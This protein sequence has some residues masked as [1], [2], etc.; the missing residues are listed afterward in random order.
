MYSQGVPQSQGHPDAVH[1]GLDALG[2]FVVD[3]LGEISGKGCSDTCSTFCGEAARLD[4]VLGV[5]HR[6]L[7][8]IAR[9]PETK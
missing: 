2:D 8:E 9:C 3:T 4:S 1:S 6:L 5:A 7:G